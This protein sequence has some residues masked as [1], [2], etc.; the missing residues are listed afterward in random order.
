MSGRAMLQ[1][2]RHF[3]S[4]GFSCTSASGER[5]A[6]PVAVA[7]SSRRTV[8]PV[9]TAPSTVVS[10]TNFPRPPDR[11]VTQRQDLVAED[12]ASTVAAHRT[13]VTSSS[14]RNRG[15]VSGAKSRASG[16]PRNAEQKTT[17]FEQW[18]DAGIQRPQ[19]KAH[20]TN[21]PARNVTR[22]AAGGNESSSRA[23]R[24]GAS[25]VRAAQTESAQTAAVK[26]R[27]YQWPADAKKINLNGAATVPGE[28][29]GVS[30][31]AACRHLTAAAAHWR[32]QHPGQEFNFAER[33]R[34]A[35]TIARNMPPDIESLSEHMRRRASQSHVFSMEQFDAV[36]DQLRWSL[37]RDKKEHVA[38]L[39]TGGHTMLLSIRKD[40]IALFDPN[41]TH[42]EVRIDLAPRERSGLQLRELLSDKKLARYFAH[43]PVATIQVLKPAQRGYASIEREFRKHEYDGGRVHEYPDVR[44]HCGPSASLLRV[45]LRD[46]NCKCRQLINFDFLGKMSKL[47][48]E[49][50]GVAR[51]RNILAASFPLDEAAGQKHPYMTSFRRNY[52]VGAHALVRF[53]EYLLETH[54]PRL[55]GTEVGKQ[56]AGMRDAVIQGNLPAAWKLHELDV[57]KIMDG[58]CRESFLLMVGLFARHVPHQLTDALCSDLV[59]HLTEQLARTLAAESFAFSLNGAN[60][61]GE[62][63][64]L[65]VETLQRSPSDDQQAHQRSVLARATLGALRHQFDPARDKRHER[66]THI[67][68]SKPAPAAEQVSETALNAAMSVLLSVIPDAAEDIRALGRQRADALALRTGAA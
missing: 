14:A 2:I 42:R 44:V 6:P 51:L 37:D 47:A 11:K 10:D 46:K 34:D 63:L 65:I 45:L 38:F 1:R 59:P 31:P 22:S 8:S 43:G 57:A 68:F 28:R 67:L 15:H 20:A 4:T 18:D 60:H 17:A 54:G 5:E 49:E 7:V 64:A 21:T 32:L 58:R 35:E 23:G 48:G 13:P 16:S 19:R 50:D 12:G 27:T 24:S 3:F 33:F 29:S 52:S 41:D 55:E 9:S 26:A 36:I 30:M 53:L 61:Q 25:P 39:R 40:R 56:T 62:L 66:Q